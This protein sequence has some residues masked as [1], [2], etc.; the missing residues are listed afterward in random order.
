MDY[1]LRLAAIILSFLK[2][3]FFGGGGVATVREE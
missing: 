1:V 2:L 3:L